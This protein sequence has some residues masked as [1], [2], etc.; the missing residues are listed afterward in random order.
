MIVAAALLFLS[1]AALADNI[2]EQTTRDRARPPTATD[3]IGGLYA[4]GRF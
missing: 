1:T 2:G 4:F 3:V